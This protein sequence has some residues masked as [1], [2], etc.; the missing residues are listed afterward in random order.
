VFDPERVLRLLDEAGV[1]YLVIVGF[2]P[3]VPDTG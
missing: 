3:E 1:A 2:A